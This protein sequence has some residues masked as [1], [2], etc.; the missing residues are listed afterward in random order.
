MKKIYDK[1]GFTMIELVLVIVVLGILAALAM[2]RMER[3]RT[4][5]AADTILSDIRYAQHMAINDY[6]E[7]PR[8]NEW[9]RT[10]WQV[11]IEGCSDEGMFI[12][13]GADKDEGE[14]LSKDEVALDPANG[15]PMF[16]KNTDDCEKGGDDTV[17]SNIFLYK[18]FGV[19]SISGSGGCD[20]V[21]HIGFDHLGRPHVSFSASDDPDYSSYMKEECIFTFDLKGGAKSFEIHI[22]PETGYSYIKTDDGIQ[23]DS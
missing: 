15:K 4:Q 9:Q 16:W 1:N 14:D 22:E 3:D 2:P 7:D 17:S 10:F 8:D 6:R 5:E 19:Y 12:M 20:G 23:D 18:K 13:V 21:Q 11:K